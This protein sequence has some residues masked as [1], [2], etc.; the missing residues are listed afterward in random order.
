VKHVVLVLAVLMLALTCAQADAY[1]QLRACIAA[2]KGDRLSALPEGYD[3]Q[4]FE[5]GVYVSYV[6]I[7]KRGDTRWLVQIIKPAPGEPPARPQPD[8]DEHHTLPD[9]TLLHV[10]VW[11]APNQGPIP[12]VAVPFPEVDGWTMRRSR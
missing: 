1:P 10:S 12:H 2:M 6:G 5:E 4:R 3:W 11:S 7:P 9:G 8:D